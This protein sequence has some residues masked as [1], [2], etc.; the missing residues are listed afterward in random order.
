MRILYAI[1]GTGNGHLTRALDIIPALQQRGELDILV[2]GSQVD[3]P[4]PYPVKYRLKG[5]GFIFGKKAESTF[6]GHSHRP[7]PAASTER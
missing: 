5:M 7:A 6:T 2:S 3:I 1:Q 4:L